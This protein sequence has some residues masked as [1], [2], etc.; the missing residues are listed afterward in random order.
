[1]DILI[2]VG[3]CLAIVTTIITVGIVGIIAE[4][5]RRE[6]MTQLANELGMD[7]DTDADI[8]DHAALAWAPL[9]QRGRRHRSRNVLK[10]P[11]SSDSPLIF[12]Y[13][14]TTGSGKHARRHTQ[15][16][17]LHRPQGLNY[18]LLEARPEGFTDAIIST[19]GWK[20][21]DYS[22]DPEFSKRYWVKADD[23]IDARSILD[24]DTRRLL[25][26][27]PRWS[28]QIKGDTFIFF[29]KDKTL[30]PTDI[31]EYLRETEDILVAMTALPQSD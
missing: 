16:V 14:Y 21:I 11:D 8:H 15:T 20:D 10:Q 31:P 2:F 19:L 4:R 23:E 7:Y 3:A 17:F 24:P 27:N 12:D 6:A 28:V 25:L 22:E 9:F 26:N 18:P 1:M 30:K 5:R 29:I 13:Q